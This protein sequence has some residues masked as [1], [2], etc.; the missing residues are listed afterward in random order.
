MS[1]GAPESS[2][3]AD[4]LHANSPLKPGL[5]RTS[6]DVNAFRV[7]NLTRR[8]EGEEGGYGAYP[9]AQTSEQSQGGGYSQAPPQQA[10]PAYEPA[11]GYD[12][13]PEGED[14]EDLPW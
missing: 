10:A 11:G 13:P 14:L 4:Y 9:P 12:Q 8:E 2:S 7:I 3:K 6:L 5:N 1:E